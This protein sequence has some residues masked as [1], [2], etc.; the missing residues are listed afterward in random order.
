MYQTRGLNPACNRQL[1]G[2][3]VGAA[4]TALRCRRPNPL[5]DAYERLVESG[6]KPNLARLTIARKIAAI[7][8]AMWKSE[9]EYRIMS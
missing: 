9:S 1:K 7:A 6:T 5:L 2:L 8:L 4:R 3:F